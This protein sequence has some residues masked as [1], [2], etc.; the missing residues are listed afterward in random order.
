MS[1][2][3]DKHSF[4]VVF[5]GCCKTQVTTKSNQNRHRQTTITTD[6]SELKHNGSQKR[7]NECH[8]SEVS[9]NYPNQ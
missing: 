9:V 6:Q 5:T 4:K 3:L 8:M 2:S 1:A 7:E